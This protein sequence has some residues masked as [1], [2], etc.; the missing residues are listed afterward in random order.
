MN[1]KL[2]L[3]LVM[4]VLA[5]A[6]ASVPAVAGSVPVSN[7]A[8]DTLVLT[9]ASPP[10]FGT[11]GEVLSFFATVMAPG[12]NGGTLFLNGDSF[13]IASPLSLDDTP[14]LLNYPL[15]MNPGD[16]YS[17]LLFTI[18]IPH[19]TAVG[20]Y[21]GYFQILGGSDGSQLN[22]ISN[23]VEFQVDVPE[24]ASLLLVFSTGAIALFGLA[25]RRLLQ[26]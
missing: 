20:A 3:T 25:R 4:M 7:P 18:T 10:T 23:V 8:S 19:G 6:M 24:P 16:K 22:P 9:L 1:R 21:N 11:P 17:G 12:S 2:I 26:Q 15:S 14:F 5:I 13:T